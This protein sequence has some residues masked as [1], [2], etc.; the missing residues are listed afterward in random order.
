MHFFQNICSLNVLGIYLINY[1]NNKYK[2][3]IK[4]K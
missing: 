2:F 4:I 3:S 1:N